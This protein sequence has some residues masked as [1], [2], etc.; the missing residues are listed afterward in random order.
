VTDDPIAEDGFAWG[1]NQANALGISAKV[2][3]PVGASYTNSLLNEREKT[4]GDWKFVSRTTQELKLFWNVNADLT[5]SQ[6]EALDMIATKLARIVCG[7]PN[8]PDHWRDIAGYATLV[9]ENLDDKP[10]I[11]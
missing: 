11:G 7:N 2:T 9:A 3:A 6:R 1:K 4:H 8:E 5:N 10:P